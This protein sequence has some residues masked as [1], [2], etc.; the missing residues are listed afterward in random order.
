MGCLWGGG[1]GGGFWPRPRDA[2]LG[3]GNPRGLFSYGRTA[4]PH[5]FLGKNQEIHFGCGKG[6]EVDNVRI[7]SNSGWNLFSDGSQAIY[8]Q[9]SED[10]YFV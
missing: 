2:G 8:G 10:I 4:N 5:R 9:A 7:P 6:D 3:S 1:K